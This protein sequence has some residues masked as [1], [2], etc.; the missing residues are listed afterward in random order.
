[1]FVRHVACHLSHRL[2]M[3]RFDQIKEEKLFIFVY[4][5]FFIANYLHC[6]VICFTLIY[7]WNLYKKYNISRKIIIKSMLDVFNFKNRYNTLYLIIDHSFNLLPCTKPETFTIIINVGNNNK[8]LILRF[9]LWICSVFC[10]VNTF[11]TIN[12]QHITFHIFPKPRI[13]AISLN[14]DTLLA[15]SILKAKFNWLKCKFFRMSNLISFKEIIAWIWL[16]LFCN[17][18]CRFFGLNGTIIT[19][20]RNQQKTSIFNI[21]FEM[22]D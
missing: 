14:C 4:L 1:M 22:I 21:F 11:C 6:C 3:C 20:N 16:F 10:F 2:T 5:W 19:N 8:A 17:G 7:L 18:S 12:I 13:I 9:N 15:N